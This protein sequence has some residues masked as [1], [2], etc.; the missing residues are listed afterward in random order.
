MKAVDLGSAWDILEREE[1]WSLL[2]TDIGLS[3]I[4]RDNEGTHLVSRA[5]ERGIP[6]I[7][8]SGAPTVTPQH[9]RD[10]LKKDHV[11]DF[12]HKQ[13]FD[14]SAFIS[15][16]QR[17]LKDQMPPPSQ[18]TIKAFISYS[19]AQHQYY[20][21]FKNDFIEHS[22]PINIEV[23]GDDDMPLG[24]SWENHLK[25]KISGC[26]IVILLVSQSFMISSFIMQ[27][28]FGLALSRLKSGHNIII[29]PVYFAP[30]QFKSA[31]ELASLQF[32]KPHGDKYGHRDKGNEFSYI[33]MIEFARNDA[34]PI[35]NANAKHYMKDLMSRLELDID[36]H[37]GARY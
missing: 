29:V 28:E 17:I 7:I 24:V 3:Q 30:C 11:E 6:T 26:D 20:P 32:F 13:S 1:N 18:K 31:E 4:S 10:F 21:I 5:A 22:K 12:F 27:N 33:D 15:L 36:K 16:V 37:F 8:V 9:V 25:G 14:R 19:H 23:F 34:Q 35:P 2:C